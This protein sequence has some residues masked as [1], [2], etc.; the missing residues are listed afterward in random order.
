VRTGE[1]LPY[2]SPPLLPQRR[3]DRQDQP[4]RILKERGFLFKGRAGRAICA[5]AFRRNLVLQTNGRIRSDRPISTLPRAID[6][7]TTRPL[8]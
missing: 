4:D 6:D 1:E 8:S 2:S 7:I 3:L 5:V